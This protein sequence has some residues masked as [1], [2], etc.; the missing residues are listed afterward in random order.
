M[1]NRTEENRNKLYKLLRSDP[2]M[3]FDCLCCWEFSIRKGNWWNDQ[4]NDFIQ[5]VLIGVYAEE[6]KLNREQKETI[7]VTEIWPEEPY[8][9]PRSNLIMKYNCLCCWGLSIRKR[10]W[11]NDQDNDFT[12]CLGRISCPTR[13]EGQTATRRESQTANILDLVFANDEFSSSSLK[14][15]K[16]ICSITALLAKVT[17]TEVY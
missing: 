6:T 3:K 15:I 17:W 1:Q 10:N 4:D 7:Q 11:W 8:K 9:L 2:I 16:K 12:Q 14:K 13:R 5:K